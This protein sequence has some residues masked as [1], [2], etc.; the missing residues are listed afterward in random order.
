MNY[1][2]RDKIVIII[3]GTGSLGKALIQPLV[4]NGIKKIIVY[5]RNE[6]NQ[7]MM[8]KK[9]SKDK[10]PIR[11]FIG[12]IRDRDRL[13]R[14]LDGVN[15]AINC[16]AIKH[17]DKAQYD[18]IEAVK[19][20]IIGTQ[21]LIDATI[22]NE[23][24][25]VIGIGS[26]KE[27][28]PTSHYGA[29]KLCSCSLFIAANS[30]SPN[31]TKF[32]TVR[33]GNFWNS[34]GSFI[35]YLFSQKNSSDTIIPLTDERMSRFF[36]SLEDGAQFIIDRL[37]YMKG[38]E[39]FLPKYPK[40][41]SLMIKDIIKKILPLAKVNIVGIRPGEK[42]YEKMI[43]SVDAR[44]IYEYED[45]YVILQDNNKCNGKKLDCD[46]KYNSNDKIMGYL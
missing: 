37:K 25:K 19:T 24:E 28:D 3:G 31:K 39:I 6:Y 33:F 2:L 44:N 8:Q 23:L 9:F 26:D 5:S 40:L 11:Y 1:Y 32:S 36:I 27:V 45:Y 16:A 22:D 42:L 46:F 21:C 13:H 17:I 43:T 41:K 35:E 20:N 12:D 18:P 29:T 7:V 30:Y 4:N 10:F 14:A 15:I 38:N 34:S